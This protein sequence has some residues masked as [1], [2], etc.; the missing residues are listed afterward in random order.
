MEPAWEHEPTRK[1]LR[2]FD[3]S[4]D[5]IARV[6]CQFKLHRPL[7]LA[8]DH[9]NAF[10]HSIILYQ[11]RHGQFDEITAAQLAIDRDVEQCQIA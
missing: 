5:G 8:L 2:R 3:P 9:R 10:S 4:Q 1:H 7:G 6:F 11:V